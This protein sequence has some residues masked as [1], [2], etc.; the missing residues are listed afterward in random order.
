[1]DFGKKYGF[2]FEHEATYEK[3][4][5]VDDAQY[6]AYEVEA[7]C[8][9]LEK[10]FWTATGAK[11][12]APYLFKTLF[13]KE[14]LTFKDFP[15]TKSVSDAA[16]YLVKDSGAETFVGRV[17]SFVCV[18]P[19]YGG[20]LLRVIGES[21]SAVTGTKDFYWAEA[22]SVKDH[23]DRINQDYYRMKCDEAIEVINKYYP[24]DEFVG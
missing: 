14:E 17:G 9:K 16:I 1:M 19:E 22:E 11:F 2:T 12:A 20:Q 21:R 18:K 13:S 8:E 10:P 24:Y 23:P 4:C 15:E 6:I 3:M 7:D 5:I